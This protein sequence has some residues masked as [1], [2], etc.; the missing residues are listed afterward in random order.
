M[1][2]TLLW[3]CTARPVQMSGIIQYVKKQKALVAKIM[4]IDCFEFVGLYNMMISYEWSDDVYGY[5]ISIIQK[6]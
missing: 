3:K 5:D 2:V 6:W 1:K 4:L